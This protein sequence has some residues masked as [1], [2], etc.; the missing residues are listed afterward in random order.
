MKPH[1]LKHGLPKQLITVAAG[2]AVAASLVSSA[3]AKR[4][5]GPNPP[6]TSPL[7]MTS[8]YIYWPDTWEPN[9]VTEDDIDQRTFSGSLNGS[10]STTYQLCGLNTDGV[11][12]GGEG[13]I[14]T[15]AVVGR[16]SDMTI[17]APDGT[18]RHAVEMSASTAK[19]VTT[20]RYAVCWSPPYYLTTDTS[21][22]PLQGGSWAI[23]LS[24]QIS[25]A[26]WITMVTMTDV[27]RQQTYCPVS[28][29]SLL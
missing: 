15:V 23:G 11:T 2:V 17:T 29:Q 9:C 6:T 18:V 13:L 20:T 28:Q 7:T 19:G 4:A 3:A 16:L 27:S 8:D 26:T 14:A 12:A 1:V 22:G 25:E 10:L 24:G 5:G 21:T